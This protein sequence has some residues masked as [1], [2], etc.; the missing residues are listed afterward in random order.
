M[1]CLKI[2][3]S[4]WP[5]SYPRAVQMRLT[6]MKNEYVEIAIMFLSVVNLALV[7]VILRMVL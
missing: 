6:A 5:K 4:D 7:V 2:C 1:A 3:S